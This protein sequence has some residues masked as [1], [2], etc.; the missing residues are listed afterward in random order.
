MASTS[1]S[2]SSDVQVLLGKGKRGAATYIGLATGQDTGCCPQYLN[3]LLDVL[4]NPRKSIDDWETIDWCKW[5]MAG[6]RTPDE[7]A[8]IGNP[9]YKNNMRLFIMIYNF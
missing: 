4:L 8:N 9:I 2:T 1:S 3:G 7:F 6:G 5:L